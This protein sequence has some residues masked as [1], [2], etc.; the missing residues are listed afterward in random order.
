MSDRKSLQLFVNLLLYHL[1]VSHDHMEM[2]GA[3][4]TRGHSEQPCRIACVTLQ[5]LQLRPG[6][7]EH[8]HLLILQQLS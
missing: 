1:Q 5:A 6:S 7:A 4:K 8:L 2:N 3:E